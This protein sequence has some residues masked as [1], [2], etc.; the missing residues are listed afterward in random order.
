MK[1]LISGQAGFVVIL[2]EPPEFR[3]H[4][5]EPFIGRSDD[6]GRFLAGAQDVEEVDFELDEIEKLD[7]R[8]GR[9]WALDRALFHL[10]M[11]FDDPHMPTD[12]ARRIS[13]EIE[14][15]V[16]D[17][18]ISA[19][20]TTWLADVHLDDHHGKRAISLSH[21]HP[22]LSQ[23]FAALCPDAFATS[24]PKKITLRQKHSLLGSRAQNNRIPRDASIAANRI[25]SD[26]YAGPD[27]TINQHTMP[28]GGIVYETTHYEIFGLAH[29][30]VGT[31]DSPQG[32][33]FTSTMYFDPNSFSFYPTYNPTIR[34]GYAAKVTFKDRPN[35]PS[36]RKALKH[37]G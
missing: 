2:S 9:A 16:A 36:R 12:R 3:P 24:K 10:F 22:A 19:E 21:S 25:P 29:H 11:L 28:L 31:S 32:H 26:R 7:V 18:G 13:A 20:L 14:R 17:H 5:R 33:D 37:Q 6:I 34:G 30:H 27:L 15:V 23:F 1:A 8:L 4:G 35:E